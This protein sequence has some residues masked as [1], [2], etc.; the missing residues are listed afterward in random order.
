MFIRVR[1]IIILLCLAPKIIFADEAMN[2]EGFYSYIFG[3]I[4]NEEVDLKKNEEIYITPASCLKSV[5]TLVAIK[6]LGVDY[7]FNTTLFKIEKSNDLLMKFSGDPTLT[8][9]D[10]KRILK[11]SANK[12]YHDIIL[13]VSEYKLTPYATNIMV[14]DIGTSYTRPV[15]SANIDLNRITIDVKPGK[16]GKLAGIINNAGYKIVNKVTSSKKPTDLKIEW[17]DR[18]LVAKGNINIKEKP[19]RIYRSP[20]N[21]K[22]YIQQKLVMILEDLNIKADIKFVA[23]DYKNKNAKLVYN[24]KSDDLQQ[25][26]KLSMGTSDNLVFD[27]IYEKILNKHQKE[28]VIDDWHHG[29]KVFKS[30][31]KRY[32][33]IDLKDALIVDGSGISRFNRIQVK[34]LYEL[35][36][37]GAEDK[38][39]VKTFTAAGAKYTTL[40]RRNLP[41][42]DLKLKTGYMLCTACLCGY[43]KKDHTGKAFVF[44]VNN[45]P[46]NMTRLKQLVDGFVTDYFTNKYK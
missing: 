24:H 19:Y 31:I 4:H 41:D 22:E 12:K 8:V 29:D 32:Y 28:F 39:F 34:Q 7:R 21:I 16:I 33:D 10:L 43:G 6:E 20:I 13:D 17:Q 2:N 45:G 9:N 5:T 30:L 26:L 40:E 14:H 1:V 3:N 42:T 11:S 44:V 15:Y 18:K 35:L 46:S 27:S 36:Q 23:E 38:I 25:I 37:K